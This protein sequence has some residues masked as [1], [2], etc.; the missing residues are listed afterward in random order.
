VV[1][2]YYAFR[3]ATVLDKIYCSWAHYQR[4]ILWHMAAGASGP[5]SRLFEVNITGICLKRLSWALGESG[6]LSSFTVYLSLCWTLTPRRYIEVQ[7]CSST[8]SL[9]RYQMDM[10]AQLHIPTAWTQEIG[11]RVITGAGQE[12]VVRWEISVFAGHGNTIIRSCSA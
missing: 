8:R 5:M 2:W 4:Q 7:K 1:H 11:D 12:A 6:A 3:Q 9:I 10:K